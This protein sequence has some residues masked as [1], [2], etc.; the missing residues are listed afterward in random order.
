MEHW[1][2][3]YIITLSVVVGLNSLVLIALLRLVG[4]RAIAPHE[5]VEER[6]PPYEAKVSI[7]DVDVSQG[8][9]V[10][11]VSPGCAACSAIAPHL[12]ALDEAGSGPKV[13]ASVVAPSAA[14]ASSYAREL[15]L[16]DARTDLSHYMDDWHI[17]RVPF[18]VAVDTASRVH[19]RGVLTT[20]HQLREILRDLEGLL[21]V[22]APSPAD[23]TTMPQSR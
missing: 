1:Q 3:I 19:S 5:D 6:G 8:L 20:G 23:V 18:F 17:S 11:F 9:L 4:Q 22:D 2:W 12:Q 14:E 13:L 7:P 15:A 21:V 10:A 16:S